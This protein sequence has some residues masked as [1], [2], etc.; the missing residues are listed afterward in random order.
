MYKAGDTS[1]G[2]ARCREPKTAMTDRRR[3]AADVRVTRR[4]GDALSAKRVFRLCEALSHHGYWDSGCGGGVYKGNTS[5]EKKRH[6]SEFSS[7]F[8][9]GNDGVRICL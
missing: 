1:A 2:L 4:S 5:L 8:F 7:S 3:E 9:S 6:K